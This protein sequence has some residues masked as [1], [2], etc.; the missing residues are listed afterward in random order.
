MST[1]LESRL[2]QAVRS[3]YE[4]YKL[5]GPKSSQKLHPLHGWIMEE[6]RDRLGTEYTVQ[7]QDRPKQRE[8]RVDGKY[9]RKKVDVA[10]LRE[11]RVLGVVSVKFPITNYGKNKHNYFESQLGETAN[12]R[13]GDIVFAHFMVRTQP[14]P[15]PGKG[16]L[17][18]EKITDATINLYRDLSYDHNQHHVPDVQCLSIFKLSGYK[19]EIVR[20]CTREDLPEVSDESFALLEGRLSAGRFFEGVVSSIESK[21][22]QVR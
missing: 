4:A 16:G 17:R 13:S 2:L 8:T 19:G 15:A 7:G 18:I 10:I 12:L 22:S 11:D 5:H 9:Y 14:T 21:W 1:H 3:A 6:L 20:Q